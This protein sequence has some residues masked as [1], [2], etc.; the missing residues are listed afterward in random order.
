MSGPPTQIAILNIESKNNHTALPGRVFYCPKSAKAGPNSIPN[1]SCPIRHA[2]ARGEWAELRFMTRAVELG[3]RVTKPWG[4][5]AP[6]DLA[7]ESRGQFLRVQV[8][9]TLFQRGHSYK[10]PRLQ[11]SPLNPRPDRLHRHLRNPRRHLVHPPHS[12]NRRPPRHPPNPHR[13][14]SKHA[15]NKEAWHPAK[16]ADPSCPV[17]LSEGARFAFRIA[18]RSRRTPCPPAIST[19]C[20]N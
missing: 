11:R 17:I 2:K 7:V 14:T 3:L 9:C 19:T 8:K 4:D 1:P 13:K 10:C 12:R 18:L 15:R 16:N 20:T 5:N 6:Y